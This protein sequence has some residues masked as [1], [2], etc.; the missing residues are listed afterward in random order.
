M[1]A[2]ALCYLRL[3]TEL[4]LRAKGLLM[5]RENGFSPPP[6]DAETKARLE[7]LTFLEGSLGAT[8]LRALQPLLRM[9]R[10]ELWQINLLK[11]A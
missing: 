11:A 9:E 4:A 6:A 7:E 10:K 8:G 3:Y 1:M 2:D 5:M